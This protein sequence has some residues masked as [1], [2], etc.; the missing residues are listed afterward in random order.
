MGLPPTSLLSNPA[1]TSDLLT[2]AMNE[3]TG[4]QQQQQ[5][6]PSHLQES[7]SPEAGLLIKTS[8]SAVVSRE[9]QVLLV[10]VS[11]SELWT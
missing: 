6:V 9:Q 1:A 3:L 8:A 4:S 5:Q 2:Q 7:A 11:E 10:P